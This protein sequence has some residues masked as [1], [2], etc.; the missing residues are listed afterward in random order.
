[1]EKHMETQQ[2]TLEQWVKQEARRGCTMYLET[3]RNRITTF[4]VLWEE[5]EGIITG[6]F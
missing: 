5:P 2:Y 1:M 6:E 3:K 4:Q